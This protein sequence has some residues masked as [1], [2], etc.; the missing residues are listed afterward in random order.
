MS[1]KTK[2]RLTFFTVFVFSLALQLLPLF[3]TQLGLTDNIL[4]T[5]QILIFIM[6]VSTIIFINS[7]RR[8]F[9]PKPLQMNCFVTIEDEDEKPDHNIYQQLFEILNDS[10]T[11]EAYADPR[12]GLSESKKRFRVIISSDYQI[13]RLKKEGKDKRYLLKGWEPLD[14]I[15]VDF[16]V[17]LESVIWKMNE[18]STIYFNVFGK[19]HYEYGIDEYLS[20]QSRIHEFILATARKDEES[21]FNV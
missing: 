2:Q 6:E 17:G 21:L 12:S 20:N 11:K 9:K 4:T 13:K 8:R 15:Q 19:H 14:F 7:Y 16:R 18:K 5:M 1:L 3:K 10:R